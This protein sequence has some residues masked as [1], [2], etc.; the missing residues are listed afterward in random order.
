MMGGYTFITLNVL[1]IF[2]PAPSSRGGLTQPKDHEIK[3][4]TL[5]FPKKHVFPKSLS[6]LA[7]G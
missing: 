2:I 5:F 3:V 1:I 6:R 7:I 4:E